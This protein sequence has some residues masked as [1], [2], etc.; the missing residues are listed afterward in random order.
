MLALGPRLGMG[1]KTEALWNAQANNPYYRIRELIL[2]PAT[3]TGAQQFEFN[4]TF[5]PHTA[6]QILVRS[7]GQERASEIIAER[8]IEFE[9]GTNCEIVNPTDQ[10]LRF[11]VMEA[12]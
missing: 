7:Q 10:E 1:A 11:T 5:L 9:S 8:Q 4:T 3:S 2:P 12:K 6:G